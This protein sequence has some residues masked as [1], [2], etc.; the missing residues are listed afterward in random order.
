M[1]IG[2]SETHKS[3]ETMKAKSPAEKAVQT[4]NRRRG[5]RGAIAAV[6]E[7]N[8]D[9]R[10]TEFLLALKRKVNAGKCIVCG[11]S[12][13]FVLQEHH[14]DRE[15]RVVIT[16]CANCHDTIRRGTLEDLKD[17]HRIAMGRKA[18]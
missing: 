16:V 11:D 18:P 13:P 12:R 5:A 8:W 7:R 15:R 4:R 1:R 14:A 6:L 3:G 10:K 2:C 9:P 17:A